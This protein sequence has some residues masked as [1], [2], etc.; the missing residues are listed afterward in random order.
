MGLPEILEFAGLLLLASTKFAVAVGVLL[1]PSTNYS[2]IEIVMTLILGGFSGVSFFYYFSNWANNLINR[3]F[4]KKKV[5]SK[6][7]RRFIKFKNKYGL[8]G[9]SFISPIII[10]LP[11]GSFLASRFFSK[12]KYTL[13]IMLV[14]VVFWSLI[15]PLIKLTY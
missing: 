13:F 6:T 1:L 12:K 8:I 2:Y 15:L 3:L 10:S 5:F 7:T 4:Q 9:I 14:G 11:V